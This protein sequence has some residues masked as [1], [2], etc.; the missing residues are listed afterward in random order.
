MIPLDLKQPKDF[1][2]RCFVFWHVR[3]GGAAATATTTTTTTKITTTTTTSITSTTSTTTKAAAGYS[4][5]PLDNFGFFTLG[6][7][8]SW[9]LDITLYRNKTPYS[10]SIANSICH[11]FRSVFS[12][13]LIKGRSR[14]QPL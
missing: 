4:M 1:P 14:L 10:L 7:Y 2:L 9:Y 12:I 11:L 5:C 3:G 6:I 13:M 8:F